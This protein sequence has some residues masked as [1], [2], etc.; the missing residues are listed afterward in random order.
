[1]QGFVEVVILRCPLLNVNEKLTR[2]DIE[3]LLRD[4]LPTAELCFCVAQHGVVEIC[5]A[6]LAFPRVDIRGEI[7]R[8]EPV[9]EHPQH[10]ALEVPPVDAAA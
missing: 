9:E 1:M 10:V 3:T 4:R 2:E 7:L 8:D 6:G 5:V